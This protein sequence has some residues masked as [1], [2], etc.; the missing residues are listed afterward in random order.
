GDFRDEGE[1]L[2]LREAVLEVPD[3]LEHEARG[4]PHGV[5]DVAEGD[6]P[7]LLAVAAPPPEVE[8]HPAV[9]EVRPERALGGELALL[10]SPL[11]EGE[12]V[13][14]LPGQARD[15]RL[16]LRHLVRG[17][18]EEGLVGQELLAERLAR[19]RAAAIQLA[20]DMLADE[21]AERL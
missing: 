9:L 21:P 17:E 2:D 19:V 6:E 8:G 5:G 10:L 20:L 1:A 16:H 14:D 13:L 12:G 7:R 18:R 11:A 3:Q 15:N 4:V